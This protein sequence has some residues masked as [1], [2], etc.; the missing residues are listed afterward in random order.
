MRSCRRREWG[1]AERASAGVVSSPARPPRVCMGGATGQIGTAAAP[2][3]SR[4]A[5]PLALS[6]MAAF[7]RKAARQKQSAVWRPPGFTSFAYRD[8]LARSKSNRTTDRPPEGGARKWDLRSAGACAGQNVHAPLQGRAVA[9]RGGFGTPR[10][11][12]GTPAVS[13]PARR[14]NHHESRR[15]STEL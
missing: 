15:G 3:A 11:R 5:R 1:A 9:D 12:P 2:S 4:R 8:R 13:G 6:A 7:L 10:T 14:W